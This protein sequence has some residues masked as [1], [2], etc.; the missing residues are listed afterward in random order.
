M[1][2]CVWGGG[3][4]GGEYGGPGGGCDGGMVLIGEMNFTVLHVC[5]GRCGGERGR[6]D[7]GDQVG[8]VMMI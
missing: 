5:I 1:C 3:G 6:G 2:V 4:G 8:D 7:M